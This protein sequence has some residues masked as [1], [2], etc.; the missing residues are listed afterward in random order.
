MQRV[1]TRTVRTLM[2]TPATVMETRNTRS[3]GF[4]Q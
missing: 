2:S 3:E 1:K 4:Y